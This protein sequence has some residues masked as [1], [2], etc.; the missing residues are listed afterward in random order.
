MWKHFSSFSW[1]LEIPGISGFVYGHGNE[2]R[3]E[4]NL[5]TIQKNGQTQLFPSLEK[6]QEAVEDAAFRFA[7]DLLTT[8]RELR[9]ES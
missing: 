1:Q 9:R 7:E 2:F 4:F 8:L 3:G 6:A 5:K